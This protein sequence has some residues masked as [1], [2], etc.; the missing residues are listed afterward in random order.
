MAVGEGEAVRYGDAE[1][2]GAGVDDDVGDDVGEG[3]AELPHAPT[4]MATSIAAPTAPMPAR[5]GLD[6]LDLESLRR[7]CLA[8]MS[9]SLSQI[10]L[11]TWVN[12]I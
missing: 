10:G 3:E 11:V 4:T 2:E 7:S 12:D 8:C 9:G 6:V 1:G 5:R